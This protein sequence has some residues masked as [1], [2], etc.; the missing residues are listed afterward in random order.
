MLPAVGL[1]SD[2]AQVPT[3]ATLLP[4]WTN[5]AGSRALHSRTMRLLRRSNVWGDTPAMLFTGVDPLVVPYLLAPCPRVYDCGATR[6]G[7]HKSGSVGLRSPVPRICAPQ[8]DA[9]AATNQDEPLM[10]LFRCLP[11]RGAALA[12]EGQCPPIPLSSG[13]HLADVG[14][15]CAP[16][17][18]QGASTAKGLR[19]LGKPKFRPHSWA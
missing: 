15:V 7:A 13:I 10:R 17:G 12:K 9:I 18:R 2:V 11:R 4:P 14:A 19:S 6:D 8:G 16:Q 5:A 1:A 3:R